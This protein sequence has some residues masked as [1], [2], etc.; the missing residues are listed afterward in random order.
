MRD[1]VGDGWKHDGGLIAAQFPR[2]DNSILA[3][4]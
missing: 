1:A 2:A 4:K 3:G